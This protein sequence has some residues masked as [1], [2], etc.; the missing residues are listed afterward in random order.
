M[1]TTAELEPGAVADSDPTAR[2]L[3]LLEGMDARLSRLEGAVAGL[4]EVTEVAPAVVAGVTDTVDQYAAAA[5]SRGVDV[6]AH[7]RSSVQLAEALTRP[8]VV[9]TLGRLVERLDTVDAALSVAEQLPGMAAGAVDTVDGLIAAAHAQGIDID[10]RLRASLALVERMSA[11][12]TV[13]ALLALT[14]RLDTVQQS[15]AIAEQLPGMAAGAV[16]TVDG[17]IASAAANGIDIDAR[18]R[19]SLA[20]VERMSA[21]ETVEALLALTDR[22]DTVQQSLAIAEQLP[23]MAA[24]AVDTVDGLIASAAANGIDVDA[25]LRATLALVER[26]SAPETVEAL[27]ALT[28]RLDTV[29]QSLELADQLPGIAAGVVDTLDGIAA[30]LDARGIRIDERAGLLLTAAEKLT[31]PAIIGLLQKVLERSDDLGRLVD[32]LLESGI[33][34]EHAVRVVGISGQALADTKLAQPAPVGAFGALRAMGEPEVQRA[35]GFA[36]QFARSFGRLTAT[37]KQPLSPRS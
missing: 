25:R 15:L 4:Q 21:P 35:L 17:L 33:F 31:D 5:R 27:L 23:G 13:E 1:S 6:D 22:L 3:A 37:G 7:L 10:G 34:E 32:T 16:D 24:G 20:L 14:D 19:A 28:D 29:A 11:P 26:M 30:S 2:I 36:L 8:E 9:T 18:L 12:E